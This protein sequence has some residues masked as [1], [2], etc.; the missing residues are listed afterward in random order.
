MTKSFPTLFIA[1]LAGAAALAAASAQEVTREAIGDWT[2]LCA[3]SG[4]PC[5]ME[6]VGKTSAGESALNMQIERLAQPQTVDGQRIEAVANILTPLGVLLQPGLRLQ[7]DGGEVQASPFFLCQQNGCV[8]R[9]PLRS[10]LLN[11]FRR[12]ARA[13]LSY[14]G[15]DGGEAREVSVDISLAGFTRAFDAL[16]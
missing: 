12:G 2:K 1:A 13:R 3:P 9:A 4:A 10:D 11:A 5:V 14:A 16:K 6:Q 15:L 7:I 8:V